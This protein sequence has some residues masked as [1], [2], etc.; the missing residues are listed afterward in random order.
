[1]THAETMIARYELEAADKD[2]EANEIAAYERQ[3]LDP[4][5]TLGARESMFQFIGITDR[6][7]RMTSGGT[8]I[9]IRIGSERHSGVGRDSVTALADL[10]RMVSIWRRTQ[11]VDLR[12]VANSY[13][14]EN[15]R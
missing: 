9:E 6:F 5:F 4:S 11:A 8:S 13:R 1:M 14:P 3:V 12:A 2:A 15:V 7:E 10:M